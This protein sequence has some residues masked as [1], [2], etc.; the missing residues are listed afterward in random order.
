MQKEK[1]I[2]CWYSNFCDKSDG[3][4]CSK[5]EHC[6]KY[7]EMEYLM[8]N[9][10][11]PRAKQKSLE[12]KLYDNC[13][14]KAYDRLSEIK[15][16]IV[17]FVDNGRN[18]VIA[19]STTGNGKT[20]W[21]IKLLHKY[22]DRVCVGNGFEV[23]GLFINVPTLLI[24]LKD[25]GDP[26]SSKLKR[27]MLNADLV[28]WDDIGAIN[29]SNYDYE[30]LLMLIESRVFAEKSNIFTTNKV[31]DELFEEAVGTKLTSR[32]W[33]DSEI[34]VLNGTDKRGLLKN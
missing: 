3:D 32:I 34:I 1:R 20:T 24:K 28:V 16:D 21:A 15:S 9:S 25:F 13:D 12:L 14:E 29:L 23:R 8:E 7:L 6:P 26:I 11:L 19:G 5:F 17:D 33:F 30:Q 10:N 4:P 18:L 22:F 2:D 27:S 31:T